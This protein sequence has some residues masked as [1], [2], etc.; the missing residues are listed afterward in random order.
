VNTGIWNYVRYVMLAEVVLEGDALPVDWKDQAAIFYSWFESVGFNRYDGQ[1]L[2]DFIDEP[3]TG[4]VTVSRTQRQQLP[5]DVPEHRVP[6]RAGADILPRQSRKKAGAIDLSFRDPHLPIALRTSE[7]DASEPSSYALCGL[8]VQDGDKCTCWNYVVPFNLKT[9]L[10]LDKLM[11]WMKLPSR[12][13]MYGQ[14]KYWTVHIDPD[15]VD[16]MCQ[17]SQEDCTYQ[18]HFGPNARVLQ[19]SWFGKEAKPPF[20]KEGM[21]IFCILMSILFMPTILPR[22]RR[23]AWAGSKKQEVRSFMAL[24]RAVC[25]VAGRS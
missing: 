1:Y 13:F 20:T 6:P 2:P 19:W 12:A 18:V 16:L 15:T 7:C 11:A 23:V 17:G 8:A 10:Y 22:L 3:P 24:N 21:V 25:S 9:T 14:M 4:P 5:T